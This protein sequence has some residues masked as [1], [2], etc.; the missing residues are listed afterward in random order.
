[1]VTPQREKHPLKDALM[2]KN[3]PQHWKPLNCC[4]DSG[5]DAGDEHLE[6]IKTRRWVRCGCARHVQRR[7][8]T[9]KNQNINTHKHRTDHFKGPFRRGWKNASSEGQGRSAHPYFCFLSSFTHKDWFSFQFFGLESVALSFP[10]D[11]REPAHCTT[12]PRPKGGRGFYQRIGFE[13]VT[14]PSSPTHVHITQ[15]PSHQWSTSH[16]NMA[17]S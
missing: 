7:D 12:V 11:K 2:T 15:L 17:S 13:T 14:W 3:S 1:M 16:L 5:Q 4:S 9:N 6:I 8:E 10:P